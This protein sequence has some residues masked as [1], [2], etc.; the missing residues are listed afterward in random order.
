M[1]AQRIPWNASA[2]L[3]ALLTC[4]IATAQTAPP[5]PMPP[6]YTGVQVHIPGVYI[7]PVP[8]APFSADVQI[9]SHQKLPDGTE[10]IRMTIN[11][12]AR[13]SSGRFYNESR[14]LVPTTFKGDPS[15]TSAR[16]YD[17]STRLDIVYNPQVRL[18]R[19]T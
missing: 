9:L 4:S 2:L 7:T 12:I 16:I 17:P 3:G 8:Y 10:I 19:E 15:L 5:T 14:L 18:A 13:D 11:H 6:D 1:F